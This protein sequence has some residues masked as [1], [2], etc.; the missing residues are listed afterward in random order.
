MAD[1]MLDTTVWI[2][3]FRQSGEL[4]IADAV[5]GLLASDRG[6]LCG[7]VKLELLQGVR[8]HERKRL[9]HLLEAVSYVET[10]R[11]DFE[12]AGERLGELRKE[13]V[14]VPSSD[15]LIAAICLRRNLKLF[16]TDQRFDHFKDLKRYP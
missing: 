12:D 1:I 4:S 14:T 5:D 10:T 6:A 8:P 13:G 9:R 3:F 2:H 15:G 11:E 16:T 7:M